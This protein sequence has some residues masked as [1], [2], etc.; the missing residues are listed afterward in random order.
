MEKFR[1]LSAR[2]PPLPAPPRPIPVTCTC[3]CKRQKQFLGVCQPD[4]TVYHQR[5]RGCD[6]PRHIISFR[7]SCPLTACA[8]VLQSKT[9]G[10]VG[11]ITTSNARNSYF[12]LATITPESS[13]KERLVDALPLTGAPAPGRRWPRAPARPWQ[14]PARAP[15]APRSRGAATRGPG[16]PVASR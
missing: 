5:V 10:E 8:S 2:P 12:C 13:R 3:A 4:G 15:S 6:G 16:A 14:P 9:W 1:G 7:I 11:D